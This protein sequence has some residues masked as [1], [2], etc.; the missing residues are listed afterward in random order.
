MPTYARRTVSLLPITETFFGSR[1]DAARFA[2]DIILNFQGD[3]PLIMTIRQEKLG[4]FFALTVTKELSAGTG[5]ESSYYG[6]DVT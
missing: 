4:D 6:R 3:S 5:T 2:S 1:E